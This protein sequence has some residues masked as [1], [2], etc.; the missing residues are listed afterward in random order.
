M[1]SGVGAMS[2]DLKRDSTTVLPTSAYGWVAVVLAAVGL[3]SWVV[4]PVV[5]TVFRDDYP[6]TD[7]FLMPVI[8]LLLTVMAAVVNVLAV[9]R[10][11]QRS[12]LSL[13][14]MGLT[15][16]ASLFFGLFVIG[17]GLSGA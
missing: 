17:E 12:V 13:V 9:W 14:A 10:G 1:E 15:V 3:G 5:T 8:G 7:T 2:D 16:M 11:Q 4:L 6:I